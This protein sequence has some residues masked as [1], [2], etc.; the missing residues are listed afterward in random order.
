[1]SGRIVLII[2]YFLGVQSSFATTI[3]PFKNLGEMAQASNVVAMVKAT[4]FSGI[5]DH[6]ITR[7]YTTFE[8]LHIISG[9]PDR[10]I[11]VK[12]D[13]IKTPRYERILFGDV[14]YEIGRIYLLFLH[15]NF[16]GSYQ[17]ILASYGIY[18]Q[19]VHEGK[20][21]LA[22]L[23]YEANIAS[24]EPY[25]PLYSYERDVMLRHLKYSLH[26]AIPWNGDKI[27]YPIPRVFHHASVRTAP[28][29]C[30]FLDSDTIPHWSD[31]PALPL[32]VWYHENGDPGCP[33][34]LTRLNTALSN[35]NSNYQG[36][37]L[38]LAGTHNYTPSCASG[39]AI[40]FEYIDW[41]DN[42]YGES[43]HMLLQFA[44]PCGEIPNLIGCS[45]IL[46][47]GGLLLTS[48]VHFEH[49]KLWRDAAYGTV[50]VNNGVCGCL[51]ESKYINLLTHEMTHALGFD[52][53]STSAGYAN[54]NSGR[55]WQ[56]TNL[57][58]QC[59]DYSYPPTPN[60]CGGIEV[61]DGISIYTPMTL[62]ASSSIQISNLNLKNIAEL[63]L[64]APTI[65]IDPSVVVPM[66]TS[67][68][69]IQEDQCN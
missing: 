4:D 30:T 59:V 67:L 57:D 9:N 11:R 46:A 42:T 69:T 8:V 41:I 61:L 20:D 54:M 27:R 14:S 62:K 26:D 63:T 3:V 50:L 21:I 33:N 55:Q 25:E 51:S 39:T 32:P 5:T 65:T 53:I 31:F 58:I 28:S 7:F 60:D 64:I 45:G 12:H 47:R 17:P 22:P 56:I 29:H 37:Q 36:I 38:D 6:Q 49:G 1:M 2:L 10:E 34:F 24:E 66:P 52:H 44:D 48:T 18:T 19:V 35:M 23:R 40:G 15:Q 43:R 68:I 16:D 13:R